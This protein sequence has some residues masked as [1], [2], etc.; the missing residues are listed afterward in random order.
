MDKFTRLT[1]VAA[2]LP[3]ANVDTDMIIPKQHCKSVGRTG[4]GAHLF[5]DVRFYPDGSERPDFVLNRAPYRQATI[6]IAGANFGCGSSREA[7]VWALGEFGIRC[8]VAPSFSDIFANNCFQ[9]GMLP[10]VL[11]EPAVEALMTQAAETPGACMTVDLAAERITAP[12]GTETA[13]ETDP[14]RRDCLLNG[15]DEIAVTMTHEADIAAYE[16]KAIA[17]RSWRRPARCQ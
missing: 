1:G 6:L 11:P 2:P 7:A 10:V 13:F 12:D 16:E 5:N 9:N 15:L 14:Y 17:G 4:F 3:M 8:V